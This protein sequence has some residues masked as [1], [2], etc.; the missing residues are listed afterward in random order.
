MRK[1]RK[2]DSAR[3]KNKKNSARFL[4]NERYFHLFLQAKHPPRFQIISFSKQKGEGAKIAPP[5]H[6]SSPTRK[7]SKTSR[8][9]SCFFTNEG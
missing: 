3:E 9:R 4:V 6:S 2:R 7:L 8:E 5:P 1:P